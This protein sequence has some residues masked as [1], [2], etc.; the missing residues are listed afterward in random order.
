VWKAESVACKQNVESEPVIETIENLYCENAE[1]V[2]C[3]GV[4]GG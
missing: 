3:Y 2:M 4:R 1:R